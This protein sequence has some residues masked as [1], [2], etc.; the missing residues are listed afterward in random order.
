MFS[1][2]RELIKLKTV[3][4]TLLGTF[5]LLVSMIFLPDLTDLF[6]GS[7]YLVLIFIFFLLGLALI[8]LTLKQKVKGKLKKF[9]LLTGASSTGFFAS[10]I[11]HNIFYAFSIITSHISVLKYLMEIL[12]V[13]FFIIATIVC[14]LGFLIGAVGSV[15]LFIKRG[16]RN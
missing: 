13:M 9:L 6:S 1:T 12:H 10:A 16:K 15:I 5:I 7:S 14:P 2:R 11:L 8:Y 4:T 3:F